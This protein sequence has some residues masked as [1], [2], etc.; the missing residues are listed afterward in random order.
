MIELKPIECPVCGKH[1]SHPVYLTKN[2]LHG[3][4]GNFSY[5]C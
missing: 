3:I 4:E 2:R 5:V 1:D